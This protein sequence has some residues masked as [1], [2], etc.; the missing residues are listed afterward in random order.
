MERKGLLPCRFAAVV[1]VKLFVWNLANRVN[2]ALVSFPNQVD[3]FGITDTPSHAIFS[4]IFSLCVESLVKFFQCD[5][6][7]IFA[8]YEI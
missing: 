1:C 8:I 3:I 6:L 2:A 4:V 7:A 5:L